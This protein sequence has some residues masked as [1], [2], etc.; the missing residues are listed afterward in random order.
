MAMSVQLVQRG[1]RAVACVA[2]ASVPLTLSA[3]G[4]DPHS[5]GGSSVTKPSTSTSLDTS[6]PMS[7]STNARTIAER[8][9]LV[10]YRAMW[11]DMSTAARTADYQDPILAEHAS[12]AALSVLVQ[13]LYSYRQEGLVIMGTPATHATITSA[14][15]AANPTVANVSDC[16]N[17]THWL[18][19]MSS[20]GL[21]NNVPGGH[22]HVSAVVTNVNGT[23]KV[24]TL[25]TGAEG[26]C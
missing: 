21:E 26:S 14:T 17:D 9:A 12:G 8:E 3:C 13:G 4:T 11:A 19:Y 2:V 20:G 6:T 5:T 18:A 25:E 7:S 24:T 10:A 16:F 15:P 23:W 22:R 1:I